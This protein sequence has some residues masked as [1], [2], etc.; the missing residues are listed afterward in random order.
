MT[1]TDTSDSR[2]DYLSDLAQQMDYLTQG[3]PK[4]YPERVEALMKKGGIAF[5]DRDFPTTKTEF[6]AAARQ[7]GIW[8]FQS[9]VHYVQTEHWGDVERLRGILQSMEK[10][11]YTWEDTGLTK[12]EFDALVAPCM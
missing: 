11:G 4:G 8:E 3:N 5:G 7:W 9:L 1:T 6:E 10:N 12:A 2:N